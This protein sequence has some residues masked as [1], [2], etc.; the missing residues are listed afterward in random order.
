MTTVL[1]IKGLRFSAAAGSPSEVITPPYDVIDDEL[2]QRLYEKSPYN[3]IRLEYAQSRP[4][5][6]H[7]VNKY[8]RAAKTFH[9]WLQEGILIREEKPAIYL[10]EQHF[11]YNQKKYKRQG[12]YCG[13]GLSPFGKGKVIPHEETL[14]QPKKDRL[15]LLRHCK[16]NFSPIFGLFKDPEKFV[17]HYAARYKKEQKP[18]INFQDHDGQLHML[19]AVTDEKFIATIQTFFQS[20][21]IYIADGH[22]RYETALQYYQEN[23]EQDQ[24]K[25][26][27]GHALMVLVNVYDEGL[28]AFP[29]HRMIRQSGIDSR[30]LLAKLQKHFHIQEFPV[31]ETQE[32]LLTLLE[33]SLTASTEAK[34]C[35]GLY[36]PE[37]KF[38]LLTLKDL[39]E[40]E[41]PFPWLDTVILQELVLQDV[42]GMDEDEIKKGSL[43]GYIRDEWEAKQQVDRGNVSYV[44][45]LNKSPLEKIINLAE[46]G[47]RMPQKS[48]YF[49]PKLVSGLVILQL[50][51]P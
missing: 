25:E 36:T 40:E 47:I 19:W 22:H 9:A 15:E 27:Y 43:L 35:F 51:T 12:I 13:V 33:K 38:F 10:Y 21:K 17:D 39:K 18:V 20:Q 42:F 24:S 11:T 32:E 3:I 44:F 5:D 26:K 14:H 31:A 49:F 45:F 6:N 2:Q 37:K 7:L 34:L 41:K 46:R 29:T 30:N 50:G 23:K 28:L 1:P 48:T 8:S 16:A 4:E